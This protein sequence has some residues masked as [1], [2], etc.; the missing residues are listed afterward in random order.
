MTPMNVTLTRPEAREA[1]NCRP[2][3]PLLFSDSLSPKP[4]PAR[5]VLIVVEGPHDV[6]CLQH[7][8]RVLQ[9]ENENL[10]NLSEWEAAQRVLFLPVGGGFLW[11]WVE[12]LAPLQLPEFHLYDRELA[13]ESGRRQQFIDRLQQRP[14]CRAQLTRKRSLE[15][16]LPG[17]LLRHLFRVNFWQT[18]AIDVALELAIALWNSRSRSQPWPDLP[19]R[20]RKKLREIAKRR[21]HAE[22]LP[23]LTAA[24]LRR[25]DPAG[26]ITDWL[27]T[28]R[29]LAEDR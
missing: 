3:S 5:P 27:R 2:P 9:A 12:R 19:D 20:R 29:Q 7:F 23:H 26:E 1:C 22:A 8:S 15:N 28:I 6:T 4:P 11:N 25:R 10:P 13:P 18:D 14:H 17:G 21:I 24:D 16:Y